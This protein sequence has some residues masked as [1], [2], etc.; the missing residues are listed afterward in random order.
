MQHGFETRSLSYRRSDLS[1][2]VF[3]LI[4]SVKEV[5]FVNKE[6]MRCGEGFLLAD[7]SF[8]WPQIPCRF[9][10]HISP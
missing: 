5:V 6:I 9:L 7:Y 2:R 8:E 10:C 3:C 1:Q 4:D